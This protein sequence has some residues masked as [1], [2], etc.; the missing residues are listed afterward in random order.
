VSS[1]VDDKVLIIE[2]PEEYQIFMQRGRMKT[3]G[4]GFLG[5]ILG[6]KD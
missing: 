5:R 3:R 4:R 1:F 6:P 2:N